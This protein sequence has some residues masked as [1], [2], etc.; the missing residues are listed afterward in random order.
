MRGKQA[1]PAGTAGPGLFAW[2]CRSN[3]VC[4]YVCHWPWSRG[5]RCP[6]K[7]A[8]TSL[9]PR[10]AAVAERPL[11]GPERARAKEQRAHPRVTRGVPHESPH[12][13]W[14]HAPS[15]SPHVPHESPESAT[16]GF[17]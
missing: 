5:L 4:K 1:R 16:P 9:C 14:S 10:N 7:H 12:A 8:S 11:P 13:P 17:G 6:S 15:D 2:C 3:S